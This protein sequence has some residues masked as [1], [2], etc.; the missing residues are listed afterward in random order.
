MTNFN[1]PLATNTWGEEELEAIQRVIRS[2]RYSMGPEVLEFERRF[3]NFFGVKH[4]VMSNSGSSANLLSLFAMKYW[5]KT[6]D[7]SARDV[8]VPALSW[9]TTF[10]PV[11]QA[12]YRLKIVDIN[13]S[14]LN[15][16][17][18]QVLKAVDK[19]TAG[20]VAVNMLGNPADLVELREIADSN[21]LFLI[22]DNCEALGAKLD[23]KFTGTF[24]DLGTFSSFYSHHIST[25]EGGITVTN[26]EELEQVARSLRAHGW[27]REL[28][29]KNYISDKTGDQFEDSFTFL[30]PGFNLRPL[31]MEGAI[32]KEQIPRIPRI[33]EGRR[34]NAE[35]YKKI[36]ANYDWLAPQAEN[37]E[38]SWFSFYF[39]LVGSAEGRRPELM[40]KLADA[41]IE[42]RPVMAGNITR[43][44]VIKH[45]SHVVSGSLAATDA[46]HDQAFLIGNHAHNLDDAFGAIDDVLQKFEEN[47]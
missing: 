41:G 3:S 40:A 22:E 17:V 34:S 29:E 26:S 8:I 33:I 13:P 9:S 31:E 43:Q 4:A 16:D 10:Y 23:G 47:L 2:D 46:V 42:T 35:T 15:L 37:G 36:C 20:I 19:N 14:T 1:F 6:R 5:S 11:V 25:M 21:E 28:P 30:L 39:R 24:G 27:S 44:P 7:S 12:G 45:L 38:S 18:E 32:G